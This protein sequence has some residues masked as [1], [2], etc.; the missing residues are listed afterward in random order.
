MLKRAL[1]YNSS[2]CRRDVLFLNFD[3]T[4]IKTWESV[5]VVMFVLNLVYVV[6]VRTIMAHLY[7]KVKLNIRKKVNSWIS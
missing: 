7:S 6:N 4:F 2:K 1:N 3:G 5:C